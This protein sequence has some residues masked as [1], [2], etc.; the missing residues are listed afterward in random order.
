MHVDI[1]GGKYVVNGSPYDKMTFSEKRFLTD[2]LTEKKK[3]EMDR[4]NISEL[5][6]YCRKQIAEHPDI[7]EGIVEAYE[8]AMNEINEGGAVS[9]HVEVCRKMVEKLIDAEK[10]KLTPNE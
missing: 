1:V 8:F 5:L 9:H 3:E 2:Y 6:S 7:Q 4:N 10:R